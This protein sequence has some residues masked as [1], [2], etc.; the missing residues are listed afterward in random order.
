MDKR[1]SLSS[2]QPPEASRI[3]SALAG[4]RDTIAD[5]DQLQALASIIF[6]GLLVSIEKGPK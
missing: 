1:C 6:D 4:L 5:D 2:L 3:K